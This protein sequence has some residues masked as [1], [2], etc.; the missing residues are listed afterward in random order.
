MTLALGKIAASQYWP[1]IRLALYRLSDYLQIHGSPIDY[2]RRRELPL[3]ALLDLTMSSGAVSQ[4]LGDLSAQVKGRT[5]G[6]P[7]C[8]A[9]TSRGVV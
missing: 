4:E 9:L 5:S 7:S 1:N 3:D 8:P 6:Y 2:Q